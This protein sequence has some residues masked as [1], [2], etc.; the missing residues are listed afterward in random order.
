M[1]TPYGVWDCL[2]GG[3]GK[4]A[5]APKLSITASGGGFALAWSAA[6]GYFLEVNHTL[7]A[8]NAWAP[9]S[10]KLATNGGVVTAPLAGFDPVDSV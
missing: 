4:P 10:H 2:R 9:A 7:A 1:F 3:S 6:A 8:P 5:G